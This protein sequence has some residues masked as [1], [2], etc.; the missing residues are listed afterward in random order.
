M[1][2]P[3]KMSTTDKYSGSV[4][5]LL[6]G[7][8][9]TTIYFNENFEDPFNSAKLIIL[10]VTAGWLSGHVINY[11]RKSKISLNSNHF[12]LVTL[13]AT[14]GIAQLV[15]LVFTDVF[16]VGLIG[17]TQRRNGFLS[18]CAFIIIL[19]FASIRMN[20]SYILRFL[21]CSVITCLL[22]S[23]YGLM[24]ITG[25]DFVKWNN[26][27]NSMI[28]TLGNPNFASALL[29]IL[30]L[31]LIC[32]LPIKSIS[33]FFKVLSIIA[34][35]VS[36]YAIYKSSSRQGLFVIIFG[37][38]FYVLLY[39]Y[40]NHAKLKLTIALVFL[41]ISGLLTAGMLQIGPLAKYIY[42]D[43][44]SVR[45]YYWDAAIKMFLDNPLFG[46]GLDRYESYFKEYR[47]V[48]YP[49]KYGF[50]ITSSNAHNVYLQF[51]STGGILVG[52]SYLL[53]LLFVFITGVRNIQR[54]EGD[55][56]KIAL[57][58]LSAWVGFQ[59]QSLISIDNIG[60]SIWG[61]VLSGCILGLS[62]NLIISQTSEL[63]SK[64]KVK[65]NSVELF[66]PLIS[67]L[68]LIPILM[69]S[70]NLWGTENA[71]RSIRQSAYSDIESNKELILNTGQD[72]IS[73]P[74]ADPN[75]KFYSALFL[76]DAG[77]VDYSFEQVGIILQNDPR[78]LGALKW[79]AEYQRLKGKF[80]EEILY[81]NKINSLDPWNAENLYLIGRAY[82]NL[83]DTGNATTAFKKIIEFAPG[84]INADKA[85]EEIE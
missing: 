50:E 52:G 26:P 10:L 84:T 36:I 77:Y 48:G 80:K 41:L 15:S 27:Y 68:I 70:I 51:F 37:L 38:L 57:L 56:Q 76:V 1:N 33:I 49:L 72:I 20:S 17:D 64:Q 19:L 34:I 73:N 79:L 6:L 61:W 11:Y 25:N 62:S 43:S 55:T 13:C 4:W 44:V 9:A 18:Y 60:L 46:I 53:L 78:H 14:F 32:L 45:G 67:T 83:G 59:A 81:R 66:Q 40:F 3:K 7:L 39:I 31:I 23:L 12:W 35:L 69:I 8:I 54:S 2:S 63:I 85:R 82:R 24:Q 16:I 75:Y 28:S 71:M 74:L 21:K 58:L 30:V 42:K 47:E 65:P 22:L 29:A 5:V